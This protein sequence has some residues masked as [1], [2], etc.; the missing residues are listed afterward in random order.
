MFSVLRHPSSVTRYAL[1]E[2]AV[3]RTVV[4]IDVGSSK[5][6]TLV[7]EVR[8]DGSLRIIGVGVAPSRGLR[9]GVVVNVAEATAAIA[10]SVEEA[11]R[12]SG[13]RIE[14]A[15]VSLGG[16]HLSSVNS[17]GVVAVSRR[18]EGIGVEDVDRALDAA[19]AIA[20]PYNRELIHVIPRHYVVDGQEGVRDPLGMHG[21]RMEVEAHVVTGSTTVIQNLVKCVAGAGVEVDEVV[22]SCLAAGDAVLAENEREIGVVLVDMGGGTTDIAIFIEGTVWH[23]V[24][25]GIGGEYITND[26][27]IGLRLPT[28][29]AEEV[30]IRYGH[31]RPAQVGPEERFPAELFG[32]SNRQTLPRWKLAEIIE[33]RVEEMLGMV[34][35]EIKRSGY[36]GLLP[37]GVVL[38]GGVAQLPGIRELA[39]E[40]VGL[41]VR[42]GTPQG[43]VGLVDRINGPAYAVAA[44][45]VGWGLMVDTRRPLPRGGPSVGRRLLR[46]LRALLPG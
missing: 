18:E 44:G 34:L 33:A 40:V 3:E 35:Q 15:Y 26:V 19:G 31:T 1:C 23:T 42:I 6:C 39:R 25:L 16:V 30:K 14:R 32:E 9:K 21:F 38:C 27:A 2:G 37:A 11:E 10:A 36:D 45:L 24:A 29:A 7:G 28:A 17:R 8:E 41:P 4:G 20:V 5:V 12:T 22:L 46:W 13:Y 43:L